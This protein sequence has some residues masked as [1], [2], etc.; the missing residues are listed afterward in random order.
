MRPSESRGKLGWQAGYYAS[1]CRADPDLVGMLTPNRKIGPNA[2]VFN[3]PFPG[4]C[5]GASAVCRAR[6][7]AFGLL[8]DRLEAGIVNRATKNL[9]ISVRPDFPYLLAGAI[10]ASGVR[11]VKAHGWG[12]FYSPAYIAAWTRAAELAPA[13]SIWAYTR[14]WRVAEL[15]D[16]LTQ[17]AAQPN[18]SL[19]LSADRETRL[20]P[21]IPNTAVA[22]F[23]GSDA[24]QP[25]TAVRVVFRG[26]I[27]R[28]SDALLRMAESP[29]CPNQNGQSEPLTCVQ[30][31]HC[32]P[33]TLGCETNFK[34]DFGEVAP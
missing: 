13:V 33:E 32:L 6:C 4:T 29:V 15:V 16:S 14:S 9:A 25:P 2:R 17:L 23:A 31:G 5:P 26:A 3:L 27:N 7:Y 8:G 10:E 1:A 24:D 34:G 12:D 20:P 19:L 18:V 28:D 21:A 30:C 11:Y 22:W